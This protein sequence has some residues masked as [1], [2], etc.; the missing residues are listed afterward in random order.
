VMLSDTE[1]GEADLVS[2][3]DLFHQICHALLRRNEVAGGIRRVL[4]EA[5]NS[6]FHTQE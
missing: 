4:H 5:V 6:D 3:R 1:R 2:E